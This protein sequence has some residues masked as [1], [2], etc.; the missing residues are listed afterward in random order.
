MLILGGRYG[1]I[2]TSSG[3]S[4]TE[5]E[6]DYAISR[7]KPLF[8]VVILSDALERKVQA[9]GTTV[10]ETKNPA[11]LDLFRKKVLSYVSSFYEDHKD[12]RLTVYESLADFSTNKELVGWVRGDNIIDT[13]PMF[14][15]IAKLSHVND[16]LRAEISTLQANSKRKAPEKNS[17]ED[18]S[19][20]L[21]SK[22]ISYPKSENE[23]D[24]KLTVMQWFVLTQDTFATGFT[25][26]SPMDDDENFLFFHIAPKLQI[27]GL[28]QYEKL[29]GVQYRRCSLTQKG[30][31]FLSEHARILAASGGTNDDPPVKANEKVEADPTVIK[32]APSRKRRSTVKTLV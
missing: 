27:Q 17:Y 29:A 7:G 11:L 31:D 30:A 15:E 14:D 20:V 13:R 25:N 2:E 32:K 26:K 16:A 9:I 1:T 4:Y 21:K 22:T 8:S 6:F 28:V 18:L 24:L 5:L 19:K 12:I 3:L 23:P 10:F